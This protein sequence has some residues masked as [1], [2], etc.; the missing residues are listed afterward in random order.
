MKELLEREDVQRLE[1]VNTRNGEGATPLHLACHANQVE[2]VE[3][4]LK[5]HADVSMK[6][7]KGMS[8]GKTALELTTMPE[9]KELFS[10]KCEAISAA[11]KAEESKMDDRSSEDEGKGV[12]AS[13][14]LVAAQDEQGETGADVRHVRNET[15]L[16]QL[17]E[18]D[19]LVGQLK[20]TIEALV[21]ELQETRM[22]G[23]ERVMLDY[24]RKLREEKAIIQRQLEDA[25]DYIN[26]QQR[27]LDILKKQIQATMP[28][29]G[30]EVRSLQL[31]VDMER[32]CSYGCWST[33][34]VY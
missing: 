28:T 9:V 20:A 2:C 4:L 18:K 15:L 6:G 27:L 10:R 26:D 14:S 7:D 29:A 8:K 17:E 32:V 33:P 1:L 30:K 23:E 11:D 12:E 34:F 21:Q 16:L 5:C 31:R 24:V 19:L 3:M 13:C 22:L 25:N